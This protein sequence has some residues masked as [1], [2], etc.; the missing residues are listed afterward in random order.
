MTDPIRIDEVLA[1][2]ERLSQSNGDGPAGFTCRELSERAGVT[3]GAVQAKLRALVYSGRV[4][5]AGK[6]EELNIAGGRCRVPVYRLKGES[7]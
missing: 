7:K 2:L 4:E 3:A 6:R 1:E 5:L